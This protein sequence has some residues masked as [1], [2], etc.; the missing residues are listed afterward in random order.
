MAHLAQHF[1]H[2]NIGA[3]VARAVVAGEEQPQFFA[4]FP[5]MAE[6]KHPADAPDFDQRAD[7]RD[8]EKIGHARALPAT[9]F[10]AA[11][12]A[13]EDHGFAG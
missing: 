11:A 9:V 2:A 8:E 4:G 3:G 10:D 7:P 12:P 13:E 1:L 6:S 5:A